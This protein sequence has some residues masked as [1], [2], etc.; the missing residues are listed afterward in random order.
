MSGF[1]QIDEAVRAGARAENE[2]FAT[3]TGTA[4]ISPLKV[5]KR[6]IYIPFHFANATL[7]TATESVSGVFP[8]ILLPNSGAAH[9]F[10]GAMAPRGEVSPG[11]PATLHVFWTT[12]ATSGVLRLVCDI[13]PVIE[14]SANLASAVQRAI[15]SS[16]NGTTVLLQQAKIPFPAALFNNNQQVS[17]KIARDPSN[18][19]DTLA[20]DIILRCV[21]L[22]ILGRC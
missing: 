13:R 3:P 2:D 11:E 7:S 8:G 15:L 10:L 1:E 9:A 16:A 22:E 18:S 14:G 21:Y 17:L 19:L 4:G 6:K 5:A 20:D 12:A